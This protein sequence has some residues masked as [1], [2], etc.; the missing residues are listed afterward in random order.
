VTV[1]PL[2]SIWIAGARAKAHAPVW[3]GFR[4]NRRLLNRERGGWSSPAKRRRREL[5]GYGVAVLSCQTLALARASPSPVNCHSLTELDLAVAR[6]AWTRLSLE[7]APG[8]VARTR[9]A[10]GT[11]IERLR[12][13][14]LEVETIADAGLDADAV[15]ATA[16]GMRC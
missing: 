10:P 1:H 16:E 12:P 15:A 13:R 7:A 8:R 5:P 6:G 3:A 4:M 9:F 11:T 2:D 14:I